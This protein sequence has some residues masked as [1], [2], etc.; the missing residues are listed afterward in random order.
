[1]LFE[2]DGEKEIFYYNN[3]FIISKIAAVFKLDL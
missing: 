3:N 2:N 1:M